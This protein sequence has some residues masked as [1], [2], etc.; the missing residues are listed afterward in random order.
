MDIDRACVERSIGARAEVDARGGRHGEGIGEI[1]GVRY[2]PEPVEGGRRPGDIGGG[3]GVDVDRGALRVRKHIIAG[4]C[5]NSRRIADGLKG[6]TLIG[7][8]AEVGVE[9]G[10]R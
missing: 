6:Q 2:A 7:F 10:R 4:A 8:P 5:G 9:P 3:D 1:R